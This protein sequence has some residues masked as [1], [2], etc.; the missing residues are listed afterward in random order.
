MIRILIIYLQRRQKLRN[1]I[2]K[3]Y[4]PIRLL[5]VIFVRVCSQGVAI[6]LN[7]KTILVDVENYFLIRFY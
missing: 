6:M 2:E 4:T 7:G 1:L 3:K 5:I